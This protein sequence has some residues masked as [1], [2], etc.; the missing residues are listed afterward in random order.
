MPLIITDH[1]DL[2]LE[3][4]HTQ[5][6]HIGI[7]VIRTDIAMSGK[8]YYLPF[9]LDDGLPVREYNVLALACSE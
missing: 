9:K 1:A 7:G 6:S 5:L 2:D 3:F 8:K 4:W